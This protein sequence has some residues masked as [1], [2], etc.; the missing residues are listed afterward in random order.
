MIK[1]KYVF[2][3]YSEA[4]TIIE[5]KKLKL[6]Y[7]LPGILSFVLIFMFYYLSDKVSF[8]L[9][10]Q[11]SSVIN[12]QKYTNLAYYLVKILV[13]IIV[14]LVYFLIYKGLILVLLSPFLNYI[15]EKVEEDKTGVKT[16]FSLKQNIKFIG[17][18]IVVSSKYL[19]F[20]ISG[21]LLLLLLG[22]LPL[23]NLLTPLIIILMQGFFA[24]ASIIDYTLERREMNSTESFG[25]VKKNLL[26]TTLS[27][28]IF[29]LFFM[30]PFL[31]MFMA[32]L[33]SCVAITRG[34]LQI[35]EEKK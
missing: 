35:L 33:V 24:G 34:T 23:F 30:V 1:L 4:F 10:N 11:L 18:G 27:G 17:R 28:T 6:F 8:N 12:L 13:A 21:T 2:K 20:E 15:S 16:N 3:G 29:I 7:M 9:F 14:F 31:G 26:F 19:I 5:R 32:P 25:F 22:F